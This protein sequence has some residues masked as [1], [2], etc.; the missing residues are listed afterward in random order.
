[1]VTVAQVF[2]WVNEIAPFEYAEEWDRVGL[3][4]GRLDSS[5]ERIL[6]AL[7]ITSDIIH[8]ARDR[9]CQCI[10]CHHP[11]LFDPPPVI[12]IDNYPMDLAANLIRE[13]ISLIVAHTNLDFSSEGTNAVLAQRL[14][15]NHTV[16][17]LMNG[18]FSDRP[19]YLGGGL[20]GTLDLHLRLEELVINTSG[21]LGVLNI[22][23]AGEGNM[24][25]SR[26]AVCSGSGGS[27]IDSAKESGA[28]CLITG[29]V[30]YH[31]IQK[32]VHIGM[33]II[34]LGHFASEVLVVSHVAEML[35][36][37]A[38]ANGAKIDVYTAKNEH[39]PLKYYKI[40]R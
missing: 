20:L 5:V 4:I 27:I 21:L 6:V 16:P 39:D 38:Q 26:V 22:V 36:M 23:W 37:Q 31:D 28:D 29:E 11:L 25:V 35:R 34:M 15:L 10:V 7:D 3:Q 8:E 2:K 19:Q 40:G 1:M 12:R 17:L 24:L 33:G 13:N 30:K 18:R 14:K 32:V 9:R